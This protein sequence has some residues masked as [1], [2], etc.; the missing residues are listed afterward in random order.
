M[1]DLDEI[2]KRVEAGDVT[3]GLKQTLLGLKQGTLA[4][5]YVTSNCPSKF[6]GDLKHNSGSVKIVELKETNEELGIICKKPYFISV[7]GL[8]KK[9]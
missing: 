5:V 2:R 6:K 4:A 7:V 3:V 8:L 9:K 1:S